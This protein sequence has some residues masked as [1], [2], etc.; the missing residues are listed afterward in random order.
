[1]SVSFLFKL[2]HNI[3]FRVFYK[4]IMHLADSCYNLFLHSSNKFMIFKFN[5]FVIQYQLKYVLLPLD[6]LDI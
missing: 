2:F 3:L 1:M 6:E 5:I 4:T